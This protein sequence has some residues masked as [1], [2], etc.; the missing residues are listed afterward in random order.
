MS[1]K[2][3]GRIFFRVGGVQHDAKGSFT[4]NSGGDKREAIV[5][6][7][8]IHGFKSTPQVPF[9]EGAITDSTDLDI[10][11]LKAIENT[12][13]TVELANGKVFTLANA[14]YAADGDLTTEEGEM[15]V[16][17]EGLHGEWTR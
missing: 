14:W 11:A 8:A 7:D 16:R 2:R 10:D 12:T 15:Q 1:N 4:C 17:F 5:G 6:A 3:A 9:V 13:V